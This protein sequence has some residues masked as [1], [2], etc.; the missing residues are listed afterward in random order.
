MVVINQIKNKIKQLGARRRASAYVRYL[1][2]NRVPISAAYLFGSY[3]KGNTNKWSDVDV[4]V[5]SPLFRTT[6]ALS[7]LW[8]GRRTEDVKNSIEPV[9]F[10]EESFADPNNELAYEIKKTGIRIG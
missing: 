6:D 9:G 10:D 1:E 2:G 7:F 3:V 5:V 8:H 4:C